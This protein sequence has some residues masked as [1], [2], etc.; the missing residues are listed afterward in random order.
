MDFK[1]LKKRRSIFI[2]INIFLLLIWIGYLFSIQVLDPH[3]LRN[4]VEI[5]QNPKKEILIPKRGNIYDCN[6]NLLVGTKKYFQLDF[7]KTSLSR[8]YK[9]SLQT[10]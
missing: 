3:N 7:D 4:L 10:K 1:I 5:R 8:N 9:D 6:K 2:A